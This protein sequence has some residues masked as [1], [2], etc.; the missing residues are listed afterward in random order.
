M[1]KSIHDALI[2]RDHGDRTEFVEF[3]PGA[4]LHRQI[5]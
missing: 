2:Q 3:L 1:L 5:F 4:S